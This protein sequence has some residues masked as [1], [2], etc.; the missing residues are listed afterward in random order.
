MWIADV[1]FLFT[2]QEP[3]LFENVRFYLAGDFAASYKGYLQDLITAA[4]GTVL[5]RKPLTKD[6]EKLFHSSPL[7]ETFIIYSLE[8]PEKQKC[9]KD[10]DLRRR[11]MEALALANASGAKVAP[12][13][14]IIDSIAA[15]KF[16][17]L[18]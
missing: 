7:L 2:F 10:A 3:K 11:Q 4:G 6:Q 9:S 1:L 16:Q 5:N 14:W 18:A 8:M 12:S 15:S 17:S 13:S